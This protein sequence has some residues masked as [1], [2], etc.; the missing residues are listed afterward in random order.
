[1]F[2]EETTAFFKVIINDKVTI[3]AA[4][5]LLTLISVIILLYIIGSA[6]TDWTVGSYLR[7]EIGLSTDGSLS[8]NFN[9]GV[10][11]FAFT[12]F[13]LSFIEYRS[14]NL[15]SLA[16]LLAFIWFDD[17]A[18][19]HEK[20]GGYLANTLELPSIAGLRPQDAGELLAWTI[21]ASMLL[22]LFIF[23]HTQKK[24]G[25]LG[26][27]TAVFAAFIMLVFF[28]I[29]IDFI[30][31]LVP[32]SMIYLEFFIGVLEDGGEMFA[33]SFIAI[34]SLGFGRNSDVYFENCKLKSKISRVKCS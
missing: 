26:L 11:F 12:M 24:P 34:F 22:P 17:A 6:T 16:V 5:C 15:L 21:A 8:E 9:Q 2:K 1:M 4:L 3:T 30:H 31:I 14:M 13:L 19:Y 28:G 7:D 10:A 27:L 29:V 32:P 18:S 20:F 25:D 23:S 33:I